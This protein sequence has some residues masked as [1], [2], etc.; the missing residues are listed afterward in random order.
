[1]DGRGLFSLLLNQ[2]VALVNSIHISRGF[3][4]VMILVL[5]RRPM[6]G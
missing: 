1:M 6:W 2:A 5:T 3:L 4:E